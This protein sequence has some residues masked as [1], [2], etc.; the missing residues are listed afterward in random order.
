[1]QPASAFVF[2]DT[3]DLIKRDK[4]LQLCALA[5]DFA[6][7][8]GYHAHDAELPGADRNQ[9][10]A[11]MHFLRAWLAQVQTIPAHQLSASQQLDR[12]LFAHYMDLQ[13]F[14]YDDLQLWEKST[15]AITEVGHLCFM[16]LLHPHA[17]PETHF[18]NITARL[19]ALPRFVAEHQ[20]RTVRPPKRWRD[21]SIESTEH[22][23]HFFD[24]IRNAPN[25]AISETLH[26]RLA[27]AV[28][29][30]KSECIRY[31]D[32]LK[33]LA[34][35][36]NESWVLGPERFAHFMRLRQLDMDPD[37]LI[38]FGE[39]SLSRYTADRNYWAKQIVGRPDIAAAQSH[40][41]TQVPSDFAAALQT[42]RN[43]CADARAFVQQRGLVD[44][45]D[46]ERL[47]V[48][49]TPP[50]LRSLI[51][52]AAIFPP[53]KFAPVQ[54][55]TYIVTPPTDHARLAKHL[56]LTSIYN[57]AVHEAY[58]GHHVQL[59]TANLHCSMLRSAP[60]VGGKATELVEGW[61]HYCEEL[62]KDRGFHDTPEGRFT[63]VGDL[64]WRA[65]RVIIDVKLSSGTMSFDEAT[66]MLVQTAGMTSDTARV[67]VNRYTQ[68]PGYQLSY[69]VGKH[70]LLELKDSVAARDGKKFSERDFHNEL[71][72][73]GSIPI[74]MIREEIFGV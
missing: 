49:E 6:T 74:R 48:I 25:G 67:E 8:N 32:W 56:N 9:L 26:K 50:F 44:L 4:L 38:A 13:N 52:F 15:D 16:M 41:E 61:A 72:R 43:A 47:D 5:P 57:T 65:A 39:N 40:I 34:V 53:A 19:D 71:L 3:H 31:L 42:T 54:I 63:M 28:L 18:A 17:D 51:A 69:L 66:A 70:L 64:V 14:F 62:M 73:A 30:A 1:M 27:T 60:F 58:P 7:V 24:A 45:P 20:S 29:Q 55:G 37:Q 12:R 11:Q 10:D 36:E 23:P 33:N 2:D 35:D 21:L 68:S 22:M 46:D 59:A